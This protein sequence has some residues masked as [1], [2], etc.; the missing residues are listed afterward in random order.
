MK[1]VLCEATNKSSWGAVSG[2]GDACT[3]ASSTFVCEEKE[4]VERRGRARWETVRLKA[5]GGHCQRRDF[6]WTEGA[7]A[8]LKEKNKEEGKED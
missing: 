1:I 8:C 3:S 2:W 7:M 5:R 6:F 4:L